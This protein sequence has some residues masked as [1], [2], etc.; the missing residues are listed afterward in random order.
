MEAL[1]HINN[2]TSNNFFMVFLSCRDLT[3]YLLYN[4]NNENVRKNIATEFQELLINTIQV[5]IC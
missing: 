3:Q 5:A 1:L 4:L 2:K